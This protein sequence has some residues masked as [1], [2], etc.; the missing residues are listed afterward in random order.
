MKRS[1]LQFITIYD[2]PFDYPGKFVARWWH[3][4]ADRAEAGDIFDVAHDLESLQEKCHDLLLTRVPR[5]ESDMPSI[6]ETWI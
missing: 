3:I 5:D 2:S 6:V 1:V 4:L